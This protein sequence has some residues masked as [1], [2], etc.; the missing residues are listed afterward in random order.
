MWAWYLRGLASHPL[1]TRALTSAAL[2]GSADVL[3]QAVERARAAGPAPAYA[4]RRTARLAAW[5]LASTPVI[6]LWFGALA[7]LPSPWLRVAADQAVFAPRSLAAFCWLC[8][9]LDGADLGSPTL[10]KF[11]GLL[12]ANWT[13]WPLFQLVNFSFV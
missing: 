1:L 8:A 3:A 10:A 5:A 11:S 7:L 6:A 13:V 9:V 2:A 12:V 4:P